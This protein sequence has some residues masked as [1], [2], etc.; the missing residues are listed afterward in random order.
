MMDGGTAAMDWA[1]LGA[2][3]LEDGVATTGPLLDPA[4][5]ARIRGWHDDPA[6]AFR[7]TVD[8]GRHNY[9]RGEYRYFDYPLPA[10]IRMLRTDFYRGLAPVAN[11]W[12]RRL[13][14]EP[15]WPADHADLLAECHREGQ[16][17]ATPLLLRYGEGDF[18]CLHQDLYGP[19]HFPLQVIILLSRPGT[20]F[21][22]GELVLVEQRPR[23]QSRPLVITLRQG[24]AAIVPVRERP[25]RSARGWHRAQMRHGVSRVHSGT[26][27]TLGLIFHD[28]RS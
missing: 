2:A 15:R 5:C 28:A 23:L 11:E 27:Q 22:G 21:T 8:M 16:A 25:R 24:E 6:I 7:K 18:N 10:E 17:Q 19:I 3:L 4:D 20:D 14:E 13:R 1:H 26:R 9:G 12:R